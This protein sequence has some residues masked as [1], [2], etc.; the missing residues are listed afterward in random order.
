MKFKHYFYDGTDMSALSSGLVHPR[1]ALA[2]PGTD[3]LLQRIASAPVGS[4]LLDKQ[5]PCVEHLC[6]TGV[7]RCEDGRLFFDCPI[8]LAQDQPALTALTAPYADAL[9][10][11]LAS[12]YK[13]M[14][15]IVSSMEDDFPAA[16]HLYHMLCGGVLDGSMFDHLEQNDLVSTGK[17]LVTMA[18]CLTI[19]YEDCLALNQFSDGLLCS[20]NRLRTEQCTFVSF[21]DSDGFRRDLYRW[22]M[23]HSTGNS[24]LTDTPL[25]EL[26][27][28]RSLDDLRTQTGQCW[29]HFM[30]GAALPGEWQSIFEH[31]GYLRHGLPC[32][33]VYTTSQADAMQTALDALIAPLLLP[34]MEEMLHKLSKCTSLTAIAH[35]VKPAD[36]ANEV[37]HI[38][39]GQIN[40][41]LMQK[42]LVT[43]PPH[44]PGEGR[45]LRCVELNE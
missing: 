9:S 10:S 29:Y 14:Q 24:A 4:V 1:Q 40:E 45:F 30:Q 43:Q 34:A 39:F 12:N 5:F 18:D 7:L 3:E 13:Q 22:F 36:L 19:L 23:C 38:L 8:I 41:K 37:Y 21:G 6:R 16:R 26:L 15:G 27:P 20:F 42:E 28:T 31:F 25:D 2:L 35:G 32:I 17:P 11:L 44:T 33:P